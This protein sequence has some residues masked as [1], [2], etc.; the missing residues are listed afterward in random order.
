MTWLLGAAYLLEILPASLTELSMYRKCLGLGQRHD[1]R[2][3]AIEIFSFIAPM[4]VSES[5]H[6]PGK[7]GNDQHGFPPDGL[8]ST[9]AL[10]STPMR[11]KRVKVVEAAQTR[12]KLDYSIHPSI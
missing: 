1:W 12:L 9:S 8:I 5:F 4:V 2:L 11:S 6:L 10:G 7:L 3:H